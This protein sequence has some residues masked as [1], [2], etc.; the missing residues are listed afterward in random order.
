MTPLRRCR[1]WCLRQR[2]RLFDL[3]EP[4]QAGSEPQ[5]SAPKGGQRQWPG[6][7]G[8]T[9][10]REWSPALRARLRI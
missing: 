10:F 3:S 2:L 7:A 5:V 1:A 8:S 4:A 6:E 9:A